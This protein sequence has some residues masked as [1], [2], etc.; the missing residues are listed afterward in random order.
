M[1][2]TPGPLGGR[3]ETVSAA[4]LA[5]GASSRMGRDKT[6][7]EIGGEAALVRIAGLLG[8]L[9]A[10]VQIV[11]GASALPA[12]TRFVADVEGPQCALRGLVTA[13]S[14]SACE[15]LLVVAADLPLVT[16]D[17]LLALI[18]WP[19]ADAVVPRGADGAQPLCALYARDPVLAVARE[20]LTGGELALSGL[21]AAIDTAYVEPAALARLDP[22]GDV[23]MNLNSPEDFAAIEAALARRN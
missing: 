9:V 21:L 2:T 3:L 12:G 11:G 20:R 16:P 22:H 17:L 13:L 1:A 7:L 19:E 6:Q 18:A 5:G 4:V 8:T 10:E 14:A 15:R 23:L